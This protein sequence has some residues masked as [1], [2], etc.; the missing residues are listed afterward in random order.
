MCLW[1]DRETRK[2]NFTKEKR[3]SQK[4]LKRLDIPRLRGNFIEHERCQH[5]FGMSDTGQTLWHCFS[6]V[7]LW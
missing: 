1:E 7:K 6:E 3:E 2:N 4:K 5:G